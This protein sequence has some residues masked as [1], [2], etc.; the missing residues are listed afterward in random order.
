M[1]DCCMCL[2]HWNEARVL[3]V[4]GRPGRTGGR[5]PKV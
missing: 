1:G 4:E 2:K 5:V 3:R